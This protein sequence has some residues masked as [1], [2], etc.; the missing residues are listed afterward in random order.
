MSSKIKNILIAVVVVG[1]LVLVYF[2][3]IKKAPVDSTVLTSS[4]G[5]VVDTSTTVDDKASQVSKDFVAV[6]LSVKN[7]NLD[8]SILKDAAFLSLHDSSINITQTGDEGRINPFAPIGS[9]SSALNTG[10]SIVPGSVVQP[11]SGN[12]NAGIVNTDVNSG[13]KTN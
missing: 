3:F 4:T 12:I 7:I 10:A 13:S 9:E 8:D 11:I 1:F 6:L 2:L 5:S